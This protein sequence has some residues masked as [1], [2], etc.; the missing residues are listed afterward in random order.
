MRKFIAICLLAG[1][2][3]A[4]PANAQ[5]QDQTQ[6]PDQ[7]Q[8][9]TQSPKQSQPQRRRVVIEDEPQKSEFFTKAA[10]ETLSGLPVPRFVSLKFGQVNGR[11]GP[12]LQHNVL[13][14]YQRK[15]LPLIVVAE[16]ENW[17]KVRDS[18]G[19]ES[20][21]R[22]VALSGNRT[23]LTKREVDIITRPRDDARIKA[24][25]QVNVLLDLGDCNES[26][27]CRVRSSDGHKGW[28]RKSDLWGATNFD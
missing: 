26:G 27:W 1:L 15:G 25:A 21:I 16:T 3:T 17:R 7:D 20:W 18:E 8:S 2:Y 11:Q 5:S 14:Q 28:A 9:Q 23:V 19:E 13:W 6:A 4:D 24:V 10:T 12:T 22:R